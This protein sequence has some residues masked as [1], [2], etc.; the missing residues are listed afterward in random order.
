MKSS[1]SQLK[2]IS[3]NEFLFSEAIPTIKCNTHSIKIKTR[4]PMTISIQTEPE[5]WL[6]SMTFDYALS[7]D[8][9]VNVEFEDSNMNRQIRE[10]DI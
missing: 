7:I 10:K 9:R 4:T 5:I 6:S 1:S 3:Q 8:H 2:R